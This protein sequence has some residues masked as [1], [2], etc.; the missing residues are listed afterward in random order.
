MPFL[1]EL[2]LEMTPVPI[3]GFELLELVLGPGQGLCFPAS[4]SL[5]DKQQ[6]QQQTQSLTS[7]GVY[8]WILSARTRR[9]G[10]RVSDLRSERPP[11]SHQ[12]PSVHLCS[13]FS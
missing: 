13:H 7:G 12:I 3:D 8:I 5:G 10:Y 4:V 1:G 2:D 9:P 11:S 6:Q